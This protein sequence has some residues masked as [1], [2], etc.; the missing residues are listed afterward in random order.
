MEEEENIN[1]LINMTV[2]YFERNCK[3]VMELCGVVCSCVQLCG[4]V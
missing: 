2:Y 3:V 1:D 4:L